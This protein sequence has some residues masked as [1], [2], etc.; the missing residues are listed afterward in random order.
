MMSDR[1]RPSKHGKILGDAL[2]LLAIAGRKDAPELPECCLTCAFRQGCMTNQMAATGKTALDCVLGID[3][4][5]FACHHGMKE[6]QPSKLCVGYI[7]AILAPW[8]FTKEVLAAVK[9]DLDAMDGP[10]EVRAAFDA[11]HD[12]ANPER[13]MDDYQLARAYAARRTLAAA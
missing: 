5:R 4:D 2:A 8:A 3:P 9:R 7:A 12:E 11:W 1:E 10:D 13:K 6:G